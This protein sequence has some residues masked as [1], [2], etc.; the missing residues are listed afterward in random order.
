MNIQMHIGLG[1]HII[2]APFIALASEEEENVIIPCYN[3]N[4]ESVRSFYV[5]HP[6]VSIVEPEY[7]IQWSIKLGHYSD[8]KQPE[9]INFIDWFYRQLGTTREEYLPHCPLL[10]ASK[11]IGQHIVPEEDFIFIHEDIEREF[12][13]DRKR[14]ASELRV[15]IPFKE[16]SILRY[17]SLLYKAKEIHCIDSSF[18][19]LCEALPTTGK[20]F[21]HINARPNSTTNY[22][23]IK[24]WEVIQ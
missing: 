19:H 17:A 15:I 5:N 21:Y 23:F 16:G 11:R 14:I 7:N 1:D 8:E 3:H 10:E 18:F 2:M 22:R 12:I 13:I 4:I 9:D 24:E 20:L 6:N